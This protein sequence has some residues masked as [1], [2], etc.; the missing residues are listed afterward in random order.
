MGRC[1]ATGGAVAGAEIT[2]VQD[3]PLPSFPISVWD[4][5]GLECYVLDW[6][7]LALNASNPLLTIQV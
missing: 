4:W 7:L 3:H 2:D 6:R 1:G 5:A